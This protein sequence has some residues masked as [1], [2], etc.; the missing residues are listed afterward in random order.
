M[1]LFRCDTVDGTYT[2]AAGKDM[3]LFVEHK[4]HGLKMMGNYTFPSL[5][6]TY[7]APGGQTAFEDEDG[8]L[9]L[10]YHQRFAKTGELHEP[11]VHQLFRTK[12]GCWLLRHLPQTARR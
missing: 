2:D 3:Y 8:K 9:Y 12:D 1:R 10:V 6:Q 4:D 5:T 11:R 7:M